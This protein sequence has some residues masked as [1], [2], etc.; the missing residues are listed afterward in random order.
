MEV[1]DLGRNSADLQQQE[2]DYSNKKQRIEDSLHLQKVPLENDDDDAKTSNCDADDLKRQRRRNHYS[3]QQLPSRAV[4][5]ARPLPTMKGHTAFLT[6]ATKCDT[7]KET[8]AASLA[9]EATS[10]SVE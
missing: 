3:V 1:P 2:H 7:Y 8:G 4:N 6:F 5:V 10:S 9:T